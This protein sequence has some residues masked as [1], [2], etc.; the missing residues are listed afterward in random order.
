MQP[1]NFTENNVFVIILSSWYGKS[2]KNYI[3]S[4]SIYMAL[5]I[6]ITTNIKFITN[7]RD[8]WKDAFSKLNFLRY[9]CVINIVESFLFKV[10]TGCY[11]WTILFT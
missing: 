4:F 9:K 1:Y 3:E 2:L 10:L 5:A 7:V 6:Y 11:S 8:K